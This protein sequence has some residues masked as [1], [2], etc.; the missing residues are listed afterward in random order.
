MENTIKVG[1]KFIS[2]FGRLV[3]VFSII[4]LYCHVDKAVIPHAIVDI[5]NNY[6]VSLRQLSTWQLVTPDIE[7]DI[8]EILLEKR[9]QGIHIV[10]IDVN[11]LREE[12]LIN[13]VI[14]L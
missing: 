8:K 3:E 12:K 4:D 13:L 11:K 14:L 7:N 9:K 6:S 1:D 2:C 10:E 5:K